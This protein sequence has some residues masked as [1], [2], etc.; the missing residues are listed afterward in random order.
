MRLALDCL[1][2][3]MLKPKSAARPSNF[4][5][6]FCAASLDGHVAKTHT[7]RVA[8]CEPSRAAVAAERAGEQQLADMLGNFLPLLQ[9]LDLRDVFAAAEVASLHLLVS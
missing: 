9:Y 5:T 8:G 4:F 1:R 7:Q 2:L 6:A 3:E